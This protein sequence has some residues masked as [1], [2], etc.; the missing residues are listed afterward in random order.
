MANTYSLIGKVAGGTT[1]YQVIFDNI[2]QTFDDLLVIAMMRCGSGGVDMGF[3]INFD[4]QTNLW[5]SRFLYHNASTAYSSTSTNSDEYNARSGYATVN[6]RT[7]NAYAYTR[8]YIPQYSGTS[9]HKIV[10]FESSEAHMGAALAG[11]T[12]AARWQNTAAV[13]AIEL[14]PSG[15]T[16][17]TF[18][19]NSTIA[20][21]GIKKT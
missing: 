2:P 14:T 18:A 3:R 11:Q 9:Y 1:R 19:D 21:Y 16:Y 20:L 13:K 12:V 15:A 10:H 17:Q 5:A 8:I 4:W 7:A 6:T